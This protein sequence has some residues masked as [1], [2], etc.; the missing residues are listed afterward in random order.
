MAGPFRLRAVSVHPFGP[1][2]RRSTGNVA[3]R[4]T[5]GAEARAV[6]FVLSGQSG[7]GHR[8]N[9]PRTR[10]QAARRRGARH[11]PAHE[12]RRV[13]CRPRAG[14]ARAFM[15]STPGTFGP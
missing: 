1:T 3:N 9:D 13:S 10:V 2:S 14:K 4:R 11:V 6:Y 8:S 12:P 5:F 7:Q 15:M